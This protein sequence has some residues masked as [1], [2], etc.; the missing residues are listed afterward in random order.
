[1][2]WPQEKYFQILN[3][4]LVECDDI[5]REV[6]WRWWWSK[7]SWNAKIQN[8]YDL[9]FDL[10]SQLCLMLS[11]NPEGVCIGLLEQSCSLLCCLGWGAK[12]GQSL[13]EK[14]WNNRAQSRRQV[15]IVTCDHIACNLEFA[16]DFHLI[17][18]SLSSMVLKSVY[19]PYPING[20]SQSGLG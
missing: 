12:V 3:W 9:H 10:W 4:I 6:E 17:W 8:A 2:K 15:I 13:V 1:M 19:Y 11:L 16:F 20:T 5:I 7:W 14:S 18:V